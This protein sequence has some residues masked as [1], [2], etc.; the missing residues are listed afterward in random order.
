MLQRCLRLC[1][2]SDILHNAASIYKPGAAAPWRDAWCGRLG[3]LKTPR[4][5][6]GG[7]WTNHI[8]GR[9]NNDDCYGMVTTWFYTYHI[10]IVY[11][12]YSYSHYCHTQNSLLSHAISRSHHE[13][14]TDTIRHKPCWEMV[15]WYQPWIWIQ[16]IK[17]YIVVIKTFIIESVK[18]SDP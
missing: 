11:S 7:L 9:T 16:R 15:I 8:T 2:V 5:T 12:I 14:L 17:L 6:L 13:W 3:N 1:L 18:Q 4:L 10:V